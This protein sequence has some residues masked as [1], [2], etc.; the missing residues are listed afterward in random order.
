MSTRI[1]ALPQATIDRIAAGEVVERPASVL[2]EIMENSLD[3]GAT[4]ITLEISGGGIEMLRLSDDGHGISREDLP[5]ALERHSTSK[6]RKLDDIE[7]VATFGFRGEA[8][9]AIASVSNLEITSKINDADSA[10]RIS[11]QN[12]KLLGVEPISREIGTTV[13]MRD[14]FAQV[15][16]RRKFLKSVS[17]EKRQVMRV[18]EQYLLAHPEVSFSLVDEG[19]ERSRYSAASLQDRVGDLLGEE[20]ARQMVALSAEDDGFRVSGLCSLPLTSRGNRSHQYLYLGRRPIQDDRARHAISQAYRDVLAPG[21]FPSCVLFLEADPGLVDVNVHPAKREVRFR[22]AARVHSVISRAISQAISGDGLRERLIKD[23]AIQL[24]NLRPEELPASQSKLHFASAAGPAYGRVRESDP[25]R[26]AMNYQESPSH[27]G[28]SEESLFWQLENTFILTRMGGGLVI[29]DQHNAHE[30]ILYDRAVEDLE[31]RTPAS[32]ELL[33]PHNLELSPSE[34]E[35]WRELGDFFAE[36]GYRMTEFGPT[37][38]AVEAIPSALRRWD[39][40]ETILNILADTLSEQGGASKKRKMALATY[41][42]KGA[43][44]A[45]Q[46]LRLDEMSSLVEELFETTS[47]Y[48]CPHGRPI[49][50]RIGRDELEK[51][52]HRVVPD[53]SREDV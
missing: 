17:G 30:R 2:K 35:A 31:G 38:L 32:Q 52:F 51:R 22:E 40:G 11:S 34:M 37:T 46:P 12:G 48:T 29:V 9:A 49:V 28:E 24:G 50:I 7:G 23:P 15:P 45:G 8:L 6:I 53:G 26:P 16:V 3:A 41:A 5:L 4:R 10:W 21:R 13:C 19:K 27:K 33:F 36:L 18:W 25:V 42:C 1:Q 14:L 43:I 47:P 39:E 44:K 20:L